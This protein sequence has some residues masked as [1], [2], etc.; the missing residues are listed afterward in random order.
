MSRDRDRLRERL[1]AFGISESAKDWVIK[2]LDP[3]ATLSTKGIPDMNACS[4]MRPEY[5]VQYNIPVPSW[6]SSPAPSSWDCLII[7]PPGNATGL[8][9]AYG[10]SG[11][12]FGSSTTPVNSGTGYVPLEGWVDQPG[13]TSWMC[14]PVSGGVP[15]PTQLG[16]FAI[17]TPQ[18]NPLTFRH[19]YSSVTID[20][21]APAVANQGDVFASQYAPEFRRS[22]RP[23]AIGTIST[24]GSA[25]NLMYLVN[26][27]ALPVREED[28]TLSSRNPYVGLAKDGVYM[29]LKHPGPQLD[30]ASIDYNGGT[31]HFNGVALSAGSFAFGAMRPLSGF[32]VQ[33]P[34][35]FA[36]A[37]NDSGG[38]T[39][40]ESP[41]INNV[42]GT[43]GV[44]FDTGYDNTNVGV[45][46]FRGLS[47][48]GGGGFGAN[49]LVKL[50]V[51]LE[52]CPRPT[53]ASR[54]YALPPHVY[55][56]RALEAYYAL[57]SEM[58][59]A[60]PSS[61]NALG[62]IIP[63]L[64]SIAS[65]LMPALSSG[66]S[67]FMR[68][69]IADTPQRAARP[70]IIEREVVK[71]VRLPA[72]SSSIRSVKSAL[73]RKSASGPKKPARKRR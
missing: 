7:V 71:T 48:G 21:I 43:S 2:T 29:P 26:E 4:V 32:D 27:C 57:A 61:Y 72:R 18:S 66:A 23:N 24:N 10:P 35:I 36:L 67:A 42:W 73:S 47:A 13:V 8:I 19:V 9:Y 33:Y 55:E 30:F 68:E 5:T 63:L 52:V 58:A 37:N 11:V 15:S 38:S 25:A 54:V 53:T 51:G 22:K 65:R 69:M 1:G 3:A 40:S 14:E 31:G 64:S 49:L 6:P 17:R 28:L 50:K 46:I 60:Y 12:D 56:P 45:V 70:K 39:G 41:W 34:Q 16:Y 62:T 20:L 59:A 44:G